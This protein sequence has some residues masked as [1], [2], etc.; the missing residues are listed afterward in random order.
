[1]DRG[2]L[3]EARQNGERTSRRGKAEWR[4]DTKVSQGRMERG[5]QVEA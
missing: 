2:H 5:H 3:V 1:M 4:E